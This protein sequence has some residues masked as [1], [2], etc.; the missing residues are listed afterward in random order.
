MAVLLKQLARDSGAAILA[1]S[2]VVKSE[3]SG[4][5]KG[6]E[7]TLNMLRGSNRIAHAADVVLRCIRK[8]RRR[9]AA[10]AAS[11]PWDMLGA[12]FQDSPRAR[13]LRGRSMTCAMLTLRAAT[14]RPFGRAAELLKTEVGVTQFASVAL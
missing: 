14:R 12:K 3:Q 4:A 1:L 2:D 9:T 8:Q 13:T 7:F 5:L 11:D 6:T 10:K